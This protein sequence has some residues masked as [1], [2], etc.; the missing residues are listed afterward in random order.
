MNWILNDPW[1]MSKFNKSFIEYWYWHKL[2][3]LV[4]VWHK[5]FE[6]KHWKYY[7]SV[8]LFFMHFRSLSFFKVM[9]NGINKKHKWLE[10]KEITLYKYYFINSASKGYVSHFMNVKDLSLA[11]VNELIAP[12]LFVV[13]IIKGTRY[14]L[15][16]TGLFVTL[17]LSKGHQLLTHEASNK[18]GIR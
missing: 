3:V 1:Q 8:C 14:L 15:H 11:I 13:N 16:T 4:L 2:L 9:N 12:A 6:R 5:F 7:K 18:K 10:I 17:S